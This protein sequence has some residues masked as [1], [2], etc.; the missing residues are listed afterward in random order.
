MN[1]QKIV[2]IKRCSECPICGLADLS[3]VIITN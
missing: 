2:T 3:K 1:R